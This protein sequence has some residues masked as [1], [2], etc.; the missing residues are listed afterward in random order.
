MCGVVREPVCGLAGGPSTGVLE[1]LRKIPVVQRDDRF[2]AGGEQLVDE[3]AVEVETR[4]VRRAL[5][6]RYDARPRD[7]EAVRV[8]AE[9]REEGDILGHAAPVIRRDSAVMT[10]ED[11][12]PVWH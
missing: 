8:H 2:D 5:P 6:G 3:R 9:L 4:G 10:V 12:A 11:P 7:R 1:R